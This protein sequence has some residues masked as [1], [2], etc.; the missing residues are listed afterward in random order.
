MMNRAML[1]VALASSAAAAGA[2]SFEITL[3]SD[4]AAVLPGQSFTVTATL[5]ASGLGSGAVAA[6]GA[7]VAATSGSLGSVSF[8]AASDINADLQFGASGSSDGSGVSAV[9]GQLSN[10]FGVNPGV[11]GSNPIAL[12]SFEA[13]AA[14]GSLDDI[15]LDIVAQLNA[16]GLVLAYADAS[17][18]AQV[19][20]NLD[21]VMVNGVTVDV[22][23]PGDQNN[24]GSLSGADFNAFLSNFT[25]G[26]NLAD[27]NGDGSLS[28][29]DFNGW[30]G[31]F[32][33]GCM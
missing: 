23:C 18:P 6:F 4:R 29:A 15:V 8:D 22:V 9:G 17:L 30:L 19:A 26:S 1:A 33:A 20:A 14:M 5:T 32:S 16:A 13:T 31:A 3:S 10:V 11:N 27:I 7:Q 24:D 12:F 28:G 25:A 2:Q 21:E